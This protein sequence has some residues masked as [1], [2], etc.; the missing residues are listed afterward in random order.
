MLRILKRCLGAAV[1]LSL[2][3]FGL[4]YYR[5]R[6]L[7]DTDGPQII[8]DAASITVSVTDGEEALR[9]HPV[10][11]GLSMFVSV[12]FNLFQGE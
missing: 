10:C 9:F 3:L 2:V 12:C 5:T 6:N 8:L 11:A 4:G 1:L 7:R